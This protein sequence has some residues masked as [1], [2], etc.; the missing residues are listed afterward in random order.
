M[1]YIVEQACQL[2]SI[3]QAAVMSFGQN[4]PKQLLKTPVPDMHNSDGV[5]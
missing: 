1:P 4:I 5:K 3:S 2:K